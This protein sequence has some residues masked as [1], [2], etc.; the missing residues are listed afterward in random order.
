MLSM[1]GSSGLSGFL[2]GLYDE[3][4]QSSVADLLNVYSNK[5]YIQSRE[6]YRTSGSI[7]VVLVVEI[8]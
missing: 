6:E 7:E 4:S 1:P 2:L 5:R 8:L 3:S